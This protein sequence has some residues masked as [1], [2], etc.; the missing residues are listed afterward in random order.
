MWLEFRICHSYS[1]SLCCDRRNANKPEMIKYTKTGISAWQIETNQLLFALFHL[2]S[3][4]VSIYASLLPIQQSVVKVFTEAL[5]NPVMISDGWSFIFTGCKVTLQLQRQT[6]FLRCLFWRG[7][8]IIKSNFQ[9][10]CKLCFK[11]NIL[12]FSYCDGLTFKLLQLNIFIFWTVQD[13]K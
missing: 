1:K 2:A 7:G 3:F 10:K 4:Q 12:Y 8:K 11:E 6:Q 5:Q 13:G 9:L